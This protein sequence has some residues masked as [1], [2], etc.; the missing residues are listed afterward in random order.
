MR[1][2]F[3]KVF[4]A[5]FADTEERFAIKFLTHVNDVDYLFK[6]I[7]V[8]TRLEHDNIIKLYSYCATEE[9][10]IALI[11]QYA[12]GGTLSSYIKSKEKIE[13]SEARVILKQILETVKYCHSQQIIHRDLK[14]DNILFNDSTHEQI[15]IIDFGIS[16]LLHDKTRAGSLNYISPEVLSG[17]DSSSLPS[18]DIWAIGCILYEMLTGRKMFKGKNNDETK[19]KLLERKVKFPI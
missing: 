14:P 6:E 16:T 9:N 1:E 19:E 7:N 17:K 18:V 4:L 15:K 10:K 3:G 13:E 5:T 12:S 2:D 11:M 8:L